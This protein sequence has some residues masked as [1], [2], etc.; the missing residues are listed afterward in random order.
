MQEEGSKLVETPGSRFV[1]ECKA[2]YAAEKYSDVL[3]QFANNLDL[4]FSKATSE[5]DLEGSVN[6]ICHLV[7]R[8]PP[9]GTAAAASG[10]AAA[11][12]ATPSV[13]SDR[14]LQ[15]LVNLFNIVWEPQSKFTVLLQ[16]L[17]F[18]KAAGH[19]DVMLNVVRAHADTWAAGLRLSPADE[20]ALYVACAD[21]LRACTRKPRTATKEAYR[22]LCR[23]LATFETATAAEAATGTT[24]AAQVVSDFLRS[25]DLFHFDLADNP[26]VAALATQTEHA[27]LHKLLNIYLTGSV[28]DF[29]AFAA[30]NAA[31]FEKLDITADAAA[32]KM[33]LLALMGLA[34]GTPQISFGDIA[35]GLDLPQAE[36]ESVVVQ[37]IG[38]R[39]IEARIDQLEEVVT[40]AKCAPRTFGTAQWKELQGQLRSWKES[41]REVLE[42]GKDEKSVLTK[43]IA[44]L[45]VGA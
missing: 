40:I 17:A 9:P 41:V 15:A 2:S 16:A 22:L 12:A 43:G 29:K 23:H 5:Q 20:R 21:T 18:S 6:I 26:A 33:R 3:Q 30:S 38:K 7:R 13:R 44:E 1:D 25:A 11:L 42:L 28:A 19:A 32:A 35:T 37:A 27:P 36:V 31:L 14:R 8:I 10:L 34:H 24:V 4:L 45:T 39:L